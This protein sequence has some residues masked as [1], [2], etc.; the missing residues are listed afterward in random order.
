VRFLRTCEDAGVHPVI[1]SCVE[2]DGNDL[3]LLA[4]SRAGYSNLSRLVSLA[5]R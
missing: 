5:H 3:V 4:R 1:G 2:V